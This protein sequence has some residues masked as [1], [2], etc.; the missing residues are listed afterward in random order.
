MRATLAIDA[1]E[2]GASVANVSLRLLRLLRIRSSAW[3]FPTL[4]LVLKRD[5]SQ[6]SP[7]SSRP[8]EESKSLSN[9]SIAF[10]LM[11]RGEGK[12]FSR[13]MLEQRADK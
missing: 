4:G 8:S 9:W 7:L 1:C 3:R 5:R 11:T 13:T 10:I 6:S 2:L 12:D